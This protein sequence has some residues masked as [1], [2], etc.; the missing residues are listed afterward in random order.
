MGVET[1]EMRICNGVA[2]SV[3]GHARQSLEAHPACFHR[4]GRICSARADHSRVGTQ[5]RGNRR[6]PRARPATPSMTK[7]CTN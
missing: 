3:I 6:V 5:A 2:V 1:C 7:I 4:D